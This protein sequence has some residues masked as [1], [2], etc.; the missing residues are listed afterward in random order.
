L[1]ACIFIENWSVKKGPSVAFGYPDSACSS[2]S[3]YS[4]FF[5]QRNDHNVKVKWLWIRNSYRSA[6]HCH[7]PDV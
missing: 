4:R 1:L 6:K 3:G 2:P 7:R 5:P